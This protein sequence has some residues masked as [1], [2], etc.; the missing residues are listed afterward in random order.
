VT[1]ARLIGYSPLILLAST[2][3]CFAWEQSFP[4][5][6]VRSD[7][8]PRIG[9]FV[10]KVPMAGDEDITKS[11]TALFG[12]PFQKRTVSY[13]SPDGADLGT[14]WDFLENEKSLATC[15]DFVPKEDNKY[16]AAGMDLR[17]TIDEET[18]D[19]T[20]NVT[21][22]GGVGGTIEGIKG[23][24][25]ATS[26]MNASHHMASSDTNFVVHG[27]VN[28][29]VKFAGPGVGGAVVLT[30]AMATLAATDPVAFR[31]RC[32]DGFISSIGQGA[33]LY[34]LL[35]AHDLSTEDKLELEFDSKASAGMGDVFS[36]NGSSNF[37]TKIDDLVTKKKLDINFVQNG[38]VIETL[39][40]SLDTARTKVA[41]LSKEEFAGP[42]S[43]F[44]TVV[45]YSTLS[46]WPSFYMINSADIRQKAV[47][48]GQ[49]LASIRY[50]LLNIREDYYRVRK[51]ND[52]DAYFFSYHHKMR[53]EDLN[54]IADRVAKEL[55]ATIKFLKKL[56]EDACNSKPVAASIP[57]GLSRDDRIW[58][59]RVRSTQL[60][61]IVADAQK[62]QDLI[63][64]FV[65]L[66]NNF[67]DYR[68]WIELPV[69]M[70]TLS[71]AD[72]AKIAGTASFNERKAAYAQS[73]YRHWVERVDQVRCRLFSEC[74]SAGGKTDAY[75][76]I[77][78]TM[79][80]PNPAINGGIVQTSFNVCEGEFE[81]ELPRAPNGCAKGTIRFGCYTGTPDQHAVQLC[82]VNR[83][84]FSHAVSPIRNIRG[85]NRC[86]Y[87]DETITCYN[88][89]AAFP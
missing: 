4:A 36:A 79:V 89:V 44:V 70:N 57:G 60:A 53:S 1:L 18:L 88:F 54:Q 39:P 8:P 34:L 29:G 77:L 19:I 81:F 58:A 37:K 15:I 22:S 85:G 11:A 35:H 63:N 12:S 3:G 71:E 48:Y 10:A 33:D 27:S 21:L 51:P 73:L 38:G 62:C 52:L 74:L 78:S 24:A 82:E 32:G 66:S 47:R 14:G 2:I 86:G 84:S 40:I 68:F 75:N 45:P 46:N 43:T 7:L 67:D 23:K 20:L 13:P 61:R 55:D 28:S 64:G 42:R 56:N 80:A 76:K 9:L 30:G 31:T 87:Q 16:Q 17:Q 41:A 72:V 83:G 65:A 69:P 26:K 6:P 49:R 50:E 59:R 5:G 25:D